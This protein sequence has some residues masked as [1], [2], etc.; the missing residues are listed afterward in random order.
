MI[1]C[2]SVE[3]AKASATDYEVVREALRGEIVI[4]PDLYSIFEGWAP[5]INVHQ[6]EGQRELD[7][8]LSRYVN[9]SCNT[10]VHL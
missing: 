1:S 10:I 9:A 2:S 6:Q 5:A 3:G 8:W 7:V 4:V